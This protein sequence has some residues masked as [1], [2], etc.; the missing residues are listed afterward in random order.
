MMNVASSLPVI[1]SR[2]DGEEP[3]L[4]LSKEPHKHIVTVRILKKDPIAGERSL[5]VLWRIGM[6]AMCG[7][8]VNGCAN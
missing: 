6:T 3:V 1:L 7:D 8:H 5:S 2:A 4:S